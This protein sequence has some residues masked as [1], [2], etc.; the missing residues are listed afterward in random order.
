MQKN[1]R[2]R[3]NKKKKIKDNDIKPE[4]EDIMEKIDSFYIDE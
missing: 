3:K 4:F 1:S 2:R